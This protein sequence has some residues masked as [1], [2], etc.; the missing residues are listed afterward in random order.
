MSALKRMS[1][2]DHRKVSITSNDFIIIS[3]NPIPGNEKFVDKVINGLMKLGA[4]VIYEDMYDVHVSGHAFQNE[5]KLMLNLV[6]PK[7]FLPVH[8]EYKH[9]KRHAETAINMGMDP[10]DVHI[11]SIG[12]VI[13][14][15]SQRMMIRKKIT[16]GNVMVDGLG[17]GD[18]GNSVLKDR[19]HLS[20]DGLIIVVVA[21]NKNDRSIM[22][23]P[24]I[25]TRGFIY[26][27]ESEE[28]VNEIKEIAAKV[29]NKCI[30]NNIRD[31]NV[32]KTRIKDDISNY[33]YSRIK[34]NPMILTIIQDID[35]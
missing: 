20:E 2:G 12:E 11:G 30:I 31:W 24:D 13:E 18:V 32:M 9:L 33:L 25:F 17:I 3:A 35:A 29:L 16:A 28:M 4:R 7:Y 5:Q 34:R 14:L 8:G 6:K 22:S 23:G 1:T 26:V 21:I 27:K 10:E 19:K 15:S